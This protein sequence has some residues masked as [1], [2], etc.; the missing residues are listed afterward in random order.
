MAT[1]L[2]SQK[3]FTLLEI[4][5]VIFFLA[6]LSITTFWSVRSTVRIKGKI[7]QRTEELQEARSLFA[8]LDRDLRLSFYYVPEDLG[9]DP[10]PPAPSPNG[11][12]SAQTAPLPDAPTPITLFKGEKSYLFFSTATHQRLYANSPENEQHYVSYQVAD[13]KLIR[14]ESPRLVNLE[15]REELDEYRKFVL[16]DEVKRFE[17]QYWSE[18]KE[19]WIDS[20][21]TENEEQLDTLP[22]IIRLE[23]EFYPSTTREEEDQ[24]KRKTLL[25]KTAFSLQQKAFKIP[26]PKELQPAAAAPTAPTTSAL[27][28]STPPSSRGT[29]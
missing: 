28:P 25:I 2:N 21:D 5:M 20:W 10:V 3:G 14:A 23:L 7:D 8:M 17:L 29:Q 19:E 26:P 13:G 24:S 4:L 9:W 18:N 15:I 6:L 16:I 22:E 12:S 11:G 27:P 1:K